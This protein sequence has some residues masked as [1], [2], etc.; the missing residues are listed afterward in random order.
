MTAKVST[1]IMRRIAELMGIAQK[2]GSL[3]VSECVERLKEM[4]HT[5]EG[6][7]QMTM[8]WPVV[9]LTDEQRRELGLEE[10]QYDE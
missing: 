5:V 9:D 7:E 1:G 2:G 10:P 3:T 8:S 4:E 6:M